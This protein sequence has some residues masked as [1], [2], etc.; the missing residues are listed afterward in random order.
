MNQPSSQISIKRIF[1]GLAITI[2]CTIMIG[3]IGMY[4]FN[5]ISSYITTKQSVVLGT[6]D[7]TNKG[8]KPIYSD[9]KWSPTEYINIQ[10][11]INEPEY[12]VK[13]GSK[14]EKSFDIGSNNILSIECEQ[15]TQSMLE[16]IP[17][18]SS[19][20][21]KLN[22]YV[23]SDNVR[24]DISC[25]SYLPAT[26]CREA[27]SMVLYMD[28]YLFLGSFESGSYSM[29]SVYEINR[30]TYIPLY[31]DF[32]D[33]VSTTLS[34]MGGLGSEVLSMVYTDSEKNDF[35]IVTHLYDNSAMENPYTCYEWK[36]NNGRLVLDREIIEKE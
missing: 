12:A 14:I 23:V 7:T 20:T 32:T 16:D 15:I 35:R 19:C 3:V 13:D 9:G 21:I 5:I 22:G 29:V 26:G 18:W 24:A 10:R 27:I 2:P 25:D 17:N 1:K 11:D 33:S 31:F 8:I 30:G 28:K 4:Y 6:Q 36:I 34:V